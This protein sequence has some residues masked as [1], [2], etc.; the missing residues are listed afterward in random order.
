MLRGALSSR[1]PRLDLLAAAVGLIDDLP[2]PEAVGLLR[3]RA[4]A[5]DEWRASIATNLPPDTDLGTWGPVGEVIGLWLH[6]AESRAEWTHRLIGR[7]E[8]GAYRM[9]GES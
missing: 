4:E 5:M 8:D 3:R 2:R 1:D 6:T 7:L 9:A